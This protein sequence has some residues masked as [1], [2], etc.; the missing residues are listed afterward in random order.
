MLNS[1]ESDAE[2]HRIVV[3][4]LSACDH[5]R[6][7]HMMTTAYDDDRLMTFP[8]IPRLRSLSFDQPMDWVVY[9]RMPMD[10][11]LPNVDCF[12]AL[13]TT[14]RKCTKILHWQDENVRLKDVTSPRSHD[15]LCSYLASYSCILE[16][17]EILDVQKSVQLYKNIIPQNAG[18][19]AVLRLSGCEDGQQGPWALK[20]REIMIISASR[21]WRL[22][23]RLGEQERCGLLYF[24]SNS[25]RQQVQ[26][27]TPS[28]RQ[29]GTS[30][31][32]LT[33]KSAVYFIRQPRKGIWEELR[34][35][36][37]T[38]FTIWE[39]V[40]VSGEIFAVFLPVPGTLRFKWHYAF[41]MSLRCRQLILSLR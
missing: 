9:F 25:E 12:R 21:H 29:P 17:L 32:L 37:F 2:A 11:Q 18:S 1:G 10:S 30:C 7:L 28:H 31:V 39:V 41:P 19:L 6:E 14:A 20:G 34:A 40:H 27:T 15:A 36:Y 35:E 5:L 16:R 22:R 26:E 8:A 13:K 24:T 23:L 33:F 38:S 4:I 3:D